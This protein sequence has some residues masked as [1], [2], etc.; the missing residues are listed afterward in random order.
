MM[1]LTQNNM[2]LVNYQTQCILV[3]QSTKPKRT[4]VKHYVWPKTLWFGNN[5]GVGDMS[6]SINLGSTINLI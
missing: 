2:G 3:Q 5:L 1:Y 6:N 4:W